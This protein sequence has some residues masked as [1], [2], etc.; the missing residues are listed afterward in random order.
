MKYTPSVQILPG[1]DV[2]VTMA[3][4]QVPPLKKT[5]EYL[6]TT[7]RKPS[8]GFSDGSMRILGQSTRY[9]RSNIGDCLGK[10]GKNVII[11]ESAYALRGK[12]ARSYGAYPPRR[13]YKWVPAVFHR[14]FWVLL[15]SGLSPAEVI[16]R[17][18]GHWGGHRQAYEV[19]G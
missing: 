14:V 8:H 13:T 9:G 7:N 17:P 11:G 15:Q 5:R 10:P 2:D 18:W 19:A 1:I 4:A 12:M 16:T 6:A 3:A